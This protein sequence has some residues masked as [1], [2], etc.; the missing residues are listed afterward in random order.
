[1]E[2][3]KIH[4]VSN[5]CQN[6]NMPVA[7]TVIDLQSTESPKVIE[8]PEQNMLPYGEKIGNAIKSRIN[9]P[10]AEKYIQGN[11]MVEVEVELLPNGEVV[12]IKIIQPSGLDAWDEA[13][14]DAIKR[15]RVFP[16]RDD[17][18]VFRKLH[19]TFRPKVTS[20]SEKPK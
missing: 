1:M 13:V 2:V 19:L 8:P 4:G 20:Y 9:W 17:G 15:L 11:P 12:N 10:V 6:P 18:T 5:R 14:I 3:Q 16:K 7:V